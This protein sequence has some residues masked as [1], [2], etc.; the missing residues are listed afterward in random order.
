MGQ[1]K[2][3]EPT[4]NPTVEVLMSVSKSFG[5][6]SKNL[7]LVMHCPNRKHQFNINV[8]DA[9]ALGEQLIEAASFLTSVGSKDAE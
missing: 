9:K 3:N 4:T 2:E 1:K 6:T 7:M 8:T 5:G